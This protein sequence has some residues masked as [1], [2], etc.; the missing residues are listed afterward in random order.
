MAC[1]T[2]TYGLTQ[3]NAQFWNNVGCTGKNMQLIPGGP[4]GSGNPYNLRGGQYGIDQ[5]DVD[6]MWIPPNVTAVISNWGFEDS[7]GDRRMKGSYDGSKI[8]N[9]HLGLIPKMQIEGIVWS[10]DADQIQLN[11]NYPWKDH[12]K[13]CCVGELTGDRMCGKYKVGSIDCDS[14]VFDTCTADDI[15]IRGNPNQQQKYCGNW[16]NANKQQCDLVKNTFCQANPKDV[17]CTCIN[18]EHD[19]SYQEWAKKF[20]AKYPGVPLNKMSYIDANGRNTCRSDTTDLV[21]IFL[22]QQV[23]QDRIQPPTAYSIQ[24]LSTTVQGSGNI[25]TTDQQ[26]QSTTSFGS[27][28]NIAASAGSAAGAGVTPSTTGSASSTVSGGGGTGTVFGSA[29]GTGI[30]TNNTT[31]P[32]PAPAGSNN[33][34]K[35]VTTTV[36]TT[37]TSIISGVD[38]LVLA[39][40]VGF[41]LIIGIALALSSGGSSSQANQQLQQM[42][43]QMQVDQYAQQMQQFN[44]QQQ[45]QYQPAPGEPQQYQQYPQYSQQQYQLPSASQYTQQQPYAPQ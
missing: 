7:D 19:P 18:L 27:S 5:D 9:E 33:N 11:I 3:P 41:L 15:K 22:P 13:K 14:G 35:P 30:F 2:P 38:D 39:L 24:D 1:Y 28:S 25:V 20:G 26:A 12:L 6:G 31:V 45:M 21:N 40:I 42:Q 16:C 32:G 17:M 34:N 36:D 43:Q 37:S 23:I 10:N 44:P 8:G 4:N 29:S